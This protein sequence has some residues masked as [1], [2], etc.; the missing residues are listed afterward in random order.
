MRAAFLGNSRRQKIASRRQF[1]AI[2]FASVSL[3]PVVVMRP[4]RIN[5][6]SQFF[7]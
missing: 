1:N 6:A 5:H 2:A 3:H 4:V 7:I